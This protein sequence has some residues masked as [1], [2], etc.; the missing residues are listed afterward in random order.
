M[1]KIKTVGVIPARLSSSRF[2]EKVIQP[3]LGKPMIYHVYCQAK[4][5]KLLNEI[6]VATDSNRVVEVCEVYSIPTILTSKKH[7]TGTDRLNEVSQKLEGDLFVNIQ[8]DEPLITPKMI[9]Q[10]IEPFIEN[11]FKGV[12]TLKTRITKE[13]DILDPNIVKVVTNTN[14]KALYFSRSPIPYSESAREGVYYKHIGLYAYPRDVLNQ[15]SNFPISEI[16][17][18]EG[19][20]QLRFLDNGI[21]IMVL[22]TLCDTIG[23]DT[24]NDLVRVEKLLKST[25]H[26]HQ[27]K[28]RIS[29]I[30]REK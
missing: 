19:L 21:P 8:G 5:S 17:K 3:I 7:K 22:E 27:A 11:S 18:Q 13:Y 6:I 28:D 14:N 9:D 20:E 26:C 25:E 24:P 29:E 15:I 16:E 1:K 10:V 30:V 4:K 23:I 2:P 12:M